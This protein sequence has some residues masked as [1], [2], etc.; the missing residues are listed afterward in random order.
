MPTTG[1]TKAELEERVAEL[2]S[3]NEDL[4]DRLESISEIVNDEG[5][6]DDDDEDGSE[7]E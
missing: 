3:E 1:P 7:E 2:E 5:D 4:R 6:E